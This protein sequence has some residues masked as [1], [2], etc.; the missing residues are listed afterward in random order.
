MF[1]SDLS[2]PW[3]NGY[4]THEVSLQRQKTRSSRFPYKTLKKVSE[5][6]VCNC[7]Q[8][9]PGLY[10]E[11]NQTIEHV[12]MSQTQFQESERCE[13]KG[14]KS[15]NRHLGLPVNLGFTVIRQETKNTTCDPWGSHVLLSRYPGGFLKSS[16]QPIPS[17]FDSRLYQW[18]ANTQKLFWPANI[19]VL[20]CCTPSRG[21]NSSAT[22]SVLGVHWP[23]SLW[24]AE[25][26]SSFCLS[27]CNAKAFPFNI[28]TWAMG[29]DMFSCAGCSVALH[30]LL[31][32]T[33][34]VWTLGT[35]SEPASCHPANQS[36]HFSWDFTRQ[37]TVVSG[38]VSELP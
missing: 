38:T 31:N 1:I 10:T 6:Q 21:N 26:L 13:Q 24:L 2:T 25:H 34:E 14:N 37:G 22:D 32:H 8:P 20:W 29:W 17:T 9:S 27:Q 11:G 18:N 3:L 4:E 15:E 7:F 36:S 12:C 35:G 28:H 16:Q 33:G 30:L 5:P 19:H 23:S